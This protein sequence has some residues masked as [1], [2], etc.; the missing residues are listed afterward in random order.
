MKHRCK[1][2][3]G[4]L[5]LFGTKVDIAL[6]EKGI[7]FQLIMVPFSEAAG[8]SPKDETVV[9][10]NPKQQVPV[11][12]DEQVE[13]FDSTQIFEYLEEIAPTPALWPGG[14]ASRAM[15]RQLELMADEIYFAQV[16]KLFGLQNDR[17]GPAAQAA[18]AVMRTYH[19]QMESQLGSWEFLVKEIS[20]ADIA[21]FMAMLFGDR[22]GCPLNEATP[23]LLEWRTRMAIRPSVQQ[24]LGPMREYLNSVSRYFP[25]WVFSP[26]G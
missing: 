3:S 7:P 5:S 22:M 18:Y 4:P 9:R 21:F 17:G 13:L 14:I 2:Y 23:K 24:A 15:A 26:T 25:A 10:V 12:I 11:L 16:V 19:Q 1:L 8:Y 20:Y 6:R